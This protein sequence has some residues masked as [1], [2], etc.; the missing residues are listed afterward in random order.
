MI[1]GLGSRGR[2]DLSLGRSVFLHCA[3]VKSRP[4]EILFRAFL[5]MIRIAAGALL[6]VFPN[7]L[8]FTG[9]TLQA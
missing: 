5:K 9:K 1:E 2:V 3:F 7:M 8:R 6:R 4:S